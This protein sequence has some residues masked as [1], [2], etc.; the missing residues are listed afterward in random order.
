MNKLVAP[1]F[2]KS[3]IENNDI[4]GYQS[5]TSGRITYNKVASPQ[6]F[7]AFSD[8]ISSIVPLD[9]V[10]DD[11]KNGKLPSIARVLKSPKLDVDIYPKYLFLNATMD[12]YMDYEDEEDQ[13]NMEELI[14]SITDKPIIGVAVQKSEAMKSAH[15]IAFIAWKTK[16]KG[17]KFAYYDPLAYKRGNKGFDFTDRAFVT[18]RFDN[19]SKLEFINLN[20]Y[21]FKS[22]PDKPEDFHCSQYVINAE[23]CYIYSV[24]FLHKWLEFGGK[25]HRASFRKAITSTYIV[26]PSKLTRANTKESMIYR[27]VMMQFICKTFL[28][29]LKRHKRYII[30]REANIE[31]I[32]KYVEDFKVKYNIDL[33]SKN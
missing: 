19:I 24:Y 33:L 12:E 23:Y 18:S 7:A 20:E 31:R 16:Q 22:N 14:Y 3:L 25:L 5:P 11:K 10:Y 8:I 27:V 32:F 15:A 2:L 13:E 29:F 30:D 21:C 6:N 26:H 4:S 28:T 1:K 9:I 17:V